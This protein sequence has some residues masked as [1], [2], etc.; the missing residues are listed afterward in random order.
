MSELTGKWI[1][2][3]GQPYAG[4]WFEFREDG[5]FEAQYEAMGIVSSGTYAVNGG[6]ITMQQIEH[7]LGFVG[8]FKGLF[9]IDGPELKMALA[10][11]PGQDRPVDLSDA[12]VYI[13]A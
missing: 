12:R 8:E 11:G 10:A 13:K 6:Q 9:E 7:T 2:K 3:E 1:Q 4:L 5:N